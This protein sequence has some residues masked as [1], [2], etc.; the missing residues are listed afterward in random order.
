MQR[1]VDGRKRYWD[2]RRTGFVVQ[3]LCGQMPVALG[4][5]QIRQGH[6]L[7][8]RAQVSRPKLSFDTPV[9]LQ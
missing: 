5:E 4:E 6:A 3:I 9:K 7:A 8:C 2:A 1:V